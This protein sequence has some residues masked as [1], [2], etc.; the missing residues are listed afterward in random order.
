LPFRSNIPEI[1]K[2]VFE[3]VDP[4]YYDRAMRH[5]QGGSFIVA[6]KNYGQGSSREH[7]ALA[8]RYLGVKA[9]LARN[10]ARIHFQNLVNFGILPLESVNPED[11]RKIRQ[12][13]VLEIREIRNRLK[14]PGS[15]E[16][17]NKSRKET[18]PLRHSLGPRQV[19]IIVFYCPAGSKELLPPLFISTA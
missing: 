16:L 15:I 9:V 4:T 8:P 14:R 12:E 13:D 10:F 3:P 6:G 17:I 19:E 2:F 11:Y 7:A 5:R 18:Y 1:S